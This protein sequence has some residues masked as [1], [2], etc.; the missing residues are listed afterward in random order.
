MEIEEKLIIRLKEGDYEAFNSLY[1]LYVSYLYNYCFKW[2]KSR[3]NTEEIV[4][5]TFIKLWNSRETIR[6]DKTLKFYIFKIINNQIK[7]C[8]RRNLIQPQYEDY[9]KYNNELGLSVSNADDQL[10]YDEFLHKVKNIQKKLTKTQQQI[11]ERKVFLNKK[12]KEIALEL[13]L[14][15][16]TVKNQLS[17]ALKIYRKNLSSYDF[18]LLIVVSNTLF[19]SI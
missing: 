15:E 2:V 12:N 1:R 18:V 3:E 4:Q 11:F 10:T 8:Y 5:D 17:L 13:S 16:Q 19:I 7:S 6:A 9:K 14:S